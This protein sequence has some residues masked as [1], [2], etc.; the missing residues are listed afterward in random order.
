MADVQIV[1]GISALTTGTVAK[2]MQRITAPANQA[3]V[4]ERV[5]VGFDGTST[6]G[7]QV[8][9]QL[10]KGAITG[11]SGSSTANPVKRDDGQNETV[12]TVGVTGYTGEPSG[13]TVVYSQY[14][15]PQGKHIFVLDKA[16]GR[17]KGGDSFAVRCTVGTAVNYAGNI[18]ATE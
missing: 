3:V 17:V 9:V 7:P 12:Q 18:F 2:T 6:T 11:G 8:L 14:V 15:H 5:E 13:G 10:I 4:V 1:Q 16:L